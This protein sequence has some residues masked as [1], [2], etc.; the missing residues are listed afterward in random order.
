MVGSPLITPRPPL[1][2]WDITAGLRGSLIIEKEP[3][4]WEWRLYFWAV[5]FRA[6]VLLP[7][8]TL[9]SSQH[10]RRDLFC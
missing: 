9:F 7:A 5:T 1:E 2:P 6:M 3:K 10:I 4:F 8:Q